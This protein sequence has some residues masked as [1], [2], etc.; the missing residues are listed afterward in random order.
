ML[1][2]RSRGLSL[3]ALTGQLGVLTRSVTATAADH[4]GV[5][6]TLAVHQ[7]A[8][9]AIDVDGDTIRERTALLLRSSG[10]EK[11]VFPFKPL[12]QLCTLYLR[13]VERTAASTASPLLQLGLSGSGARLS[14]YRNASGN[15]TVQHHNG[16]TSTT[17]TVA[18]A[19]TLNAIHELRVV[20]RASGQCQLYQSISGGGEATSGA[21]AGSPAL[22]TAWGA[23]TCTLNVAD[24]GTS[25]GADWLTLAV[26][27]GEVALADCQRVQ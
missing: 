24:A 15:H 17:A 10:T 6:R 3:E 25:G 23:L 5:S 21:S 14:I 26:V 12:P 2:W 1:A 16:T 22:A 4:L 13:F 11:L 19:P 20:L 7:A 8:W 18:T 9:G 27:A